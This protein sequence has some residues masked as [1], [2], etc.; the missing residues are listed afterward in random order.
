MQAKL[1]LLQIVQ[2]RDGLRPVFGAAQR[3]QQQRGENA[4]DR[5]DDQQLNQGERLPVYPYVHGLGN[6]ITIAEPDKIA[7]WKPAAGRFCVSEHGLDTFALAAGR[8]AAIMP[9]GCRGK[10]AAN[11]HRM[12]QELSSFAARLRELIS[13]PRSAIDDSQF[14]RLALELFALQ[15]QNNF[16][17]RKICEAR[18]RTPQTVEHWT[19]IPAVP[20]AAF[21]EL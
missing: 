10:P 21:K 20:T 2:A 8:F 1:K 9:F 18:E 14:N 15:I 3:R 12:N 4:D 17:Y 11:K 13:R 7:T 5:D 19:Q 16:A 6:F